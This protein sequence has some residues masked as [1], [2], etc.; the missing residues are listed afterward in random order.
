M[1]GQLKKK[2]F[3]EGIITAKSGLHIGGNSVGMAIGGADATVIRNPLSNEPYI[4]GSSLKGKMRSLIEKVEG[5]FGAKGIGDQI[6]NAPFTDDP[7]NIICKIFGTMPE[8]MKSKKDEQPTSRLIVRDCELT[9]NSRDKLF[10]SKNTDMPY[11]EVKT[12][13]VIDRITSAA[14][15]RQ[16]ERVPAGAEFNM[17]LVLNTYDGDKELELINKVLEALALVQNDYLGGKGTRGSGEV[18]ITINDLKYKDKDAYEKQNE[19]KI[20][21]G[22]PIPVELKLENN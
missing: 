12:E 18:K 6:Q 22:I 7:S 5:T 13:V 8:I 19:W 9:E 14:T 15:P 16:L 21:N 17:R 10:G 20:L 11:T 1:N 4:P 3:I 2:I